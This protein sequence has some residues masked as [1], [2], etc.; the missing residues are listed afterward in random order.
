MTYINIVFQKK[1]KDKLVKDTMFDSVTLVLYQFSYLLHH[2]YKR[3]IIRAEVI[4]I[5]R[6]GHRDL[7]SS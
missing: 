5:S 1:E 3:N 2:Q 4:I 7:K 6:T